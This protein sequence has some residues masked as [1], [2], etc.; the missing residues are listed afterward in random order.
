MAKW[1]YTLHWGKQLRESIKDEDTKM[2]V[3]CLIACYRE[4]LNKLSD[5]DMEWKQF[6]IEDEIACLE[7]YDEDDEDEIDFCLAEFY[8]ICDDVGAWVAI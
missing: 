2:V 8:D 3:K 1:N 6:D 7:N 4:L 5:D